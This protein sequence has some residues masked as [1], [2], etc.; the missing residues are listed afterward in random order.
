MG[1]RTNP[2][3]EE[4]RYSFVMCAVAYAAAAAV[5]LLC[6]LNLSALPRLAMV[7]GA[8]V[9]ATL[10][11][12]GFSVTFRNS[13]FYDPYWSVAPLP[14]VIYWALF[15]LD[16]EADAVRR[17]LVTALVLAWGLRLTW[18]WGR[19]WRGVRHEDWRY[20]ELRERWGTSFWIVDVCGIHLFPTLIVFLGLLP[21]YAALSVSSAPPGVLD[22]VALM[23]TASAVFIEARA[24]RE[25]RDFKTSKPEPGE[26]LQAGL[27]A[28]SRHP[29]YLGECMFWWGLYL[30]GLA[31]G[32]SWWWTGLGAA[33][34]TSMFW[35]I[36]IPMMEKRMLARRPD[37]A[38]HMARVPRLFPAR[39][40][41]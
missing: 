10:A 4:T 41:G 39:P 12:W 18:N 32:P 37:Y 23:I 21:A 28:W 9:A 5:G 25:L 1:V 11:I 3:G 22:L 16:P 6:A 38:R 15:P 17:C 31:A 33:A 20:S 36:S 27:W 35:F 14:I 26:F 7:L 40:R 29:N 8:D 30:F 19:G 34:I 24:D 13:S 2:S